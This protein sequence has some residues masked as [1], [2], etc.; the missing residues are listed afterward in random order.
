MLVARYN[1]HKQLHQSAKQTTKKA[2]KKKNTV[3]QNIR[4]IC[5]NKKK[6]KN[7]SEV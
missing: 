5:P 3:N 2:P 4:T 7:E 6:K 1:E